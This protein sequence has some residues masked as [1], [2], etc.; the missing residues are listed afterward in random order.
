MWETQNVQ[1]QNFMLLYRSCEV[2]NRV[3]WT[4]MVLQQIQG[5]SSVLVAYNALSAALSGV[6]PDDRFNVPW[7]EQLSRHPPSSPCCQPVWDAVKEG[8]REIWH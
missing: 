6:H 2:A 8:Y 3:Q 5:F 7:S 1:G 4:F